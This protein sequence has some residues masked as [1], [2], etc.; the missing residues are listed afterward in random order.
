[1]SAT[2]CGILISIS[3][4]GGVI[5]SITLLSSVEMST[6]GVVSLYESFGNVPDLLVDDFFAP[7]RLGVAG[8]IETFNAGAATTDGNTET[9]TDVGS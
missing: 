7:P 8:V 2:S 3:T 5:M 4:I 1:V 6:L 9:P